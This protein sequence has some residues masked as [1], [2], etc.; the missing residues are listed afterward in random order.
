MR[1]HQLTWV[2]LA[3]TMIC[4]SP[5]FAKDWYVSSTDTAASDSN[6]GT[7]AAAPFKTLGKLLQLGKFEDRLRSLAPAPAARDARSG[8]ARVPIGQRRARGCNHRCA[9]RCGREGRGARHEF[10]SAAR[11]STPAG[12][13]AATAATGLFRG[14]GRSPDQR[15]RL[16]L[17]IDRDRR[18]RGRCEAPAQKPLVWTVQPGS[19]HR[20]Q[21]G[22]VKVLAAAL[23]CFSCQSS[24]SSTTGANSPPCISR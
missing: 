6:V 4:S 10:G 8:G 2:A 11:R 23:L 16:G 1:H 13:K 19:L 15:H 18:R 24:Q 20:L 12:R 5:S 17:R 21:S 22:P 9:G 14:M 3:A 7:S